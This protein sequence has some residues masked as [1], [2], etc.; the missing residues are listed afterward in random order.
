VGET[1][2]AKIARQLEESKQRPFARVLFG[3]GVRNVGR[4]VAE[5]LVQH[6][7]S[8]DALKAASQEDLEVIDGVG[9]VIARTII[10]FFATE[11]NNEL[12]NRLKALGLKLEAEE[13]AFAQDGQGAAILPLQGLSFVLTGS[14]EHHV[15]EDAEEALR[16]L[17]AKTPGSVSSK[18]S[19][20][21]AGPGAG[22]KLQKAEK[23]GIPILDEAALEHILATGALPE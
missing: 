3:M 16:A 22:S 18:T 23:L 9:P 1:V 15:R 14:L 19:Y 10:E 7:G 8:L 4:Q 13:A 5:V 17:G 21:I 6:F 12:C 2:A 11:Q 20:V